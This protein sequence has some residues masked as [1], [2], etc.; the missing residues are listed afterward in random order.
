MKKLLVILMALSVSLGGFAE[1]SLND[2]TQKAQ[3]FFAKAG[4]GKK[5]AAEKPKLA[6]TADNQA[7]YVFNNGPQ[8]V[9][10]GD[11]I[12]G[13]SENGAFEYDK[14]PE[15]FKFYLKELQQGVSAK[16][17]KLVGVQ[18]IEPLTGAE[19]DQDSPYWGKIP[20]DSYLTGCVA[21]AL[22]QIMY[23][24]KHPVQGTGSKEYTYN[25]QQFSADFGNTTYDWANM[26]PTY[27]YSDTQ[28][29]KDAVATLMYHVGVAVS[30]KYGTSASTAVSRDAVFALYDYFGYD[31]G[32]ANETRSKYS[33]DAWKELIYNELAAGRPVFYSGS[34]GDSGHAFV[35]E[36][37]RPSDDK[38][39]F[40]WGWSGSGNGWFALNTSVYGYSG[41]EALCG[42]QPAQSPANI[43]MRMMGTAGQLTTC[44]T[45]RT[46]VTSL[47]VGEKFRLASDYRVRAC[48]ATNVDVGVRIQKIG[49]SE[50]TDVLAY[51][52]LNFN[53]STSYGEMNNI[54]TDGVNFS[55]LCEVRP[56]W[57]LAGTTD[58]QLMETGPD[59]EAPRLTISDGSHIHD[60]HATSNGDG[61]HTFTC[62]GCDYNAT[63]DCTFVNGEC[64]ICHAQE[65]TES[66]T[67]FIQDAV[68]NLF[69]VMDTNTNSGGSSTALSLGTEG[70]EFVVDGYPG[71]TVTISTE[72]GRQLGISTIKA[73]NFTNNSSASWTLNEV[74]D[75]IYKIQSSQGY[76]KQDGTGVG[77]TL[78]TDGGISAARTYRLIKTSEMGLN[79]A[80]LDAAIEEAQKRAI[81]DM[82]VVNFQGLTASAWATAI[83]NAQNVRD[84]ATTQDAVNTAA[85]TLNSTMN[86]LTRVQPKTG[87]TFYLK[88]VDTGKYLHLGSSVTVSDE[89]TALTLT[90]GTHGFTITDG[91]GH[92][93]SYNNAWGSLKATGSAIDFAI[94]NI[95]T[96]TVAFDA[97]NIGGS[98]ESL[99][100][101]NAPNCDIYRSYDKSFTHWQIEKVS[102]PMGTAELDDTGAYTSDMAGLY[103]SV[104]YTRNYSHT[105]WQA[106]Q[107]PFEMDYDDWKDDFIVARINTVHVKGESAALEVVTLKTGKL[108]A[109][110][111]YMIKPKTPGVKT[112]TAENV[113]LGLAQNGVIDCSSMDYIFTITG[114]YAPVTDMM[115]KGYYAMSNGALKQALNDDSSLSPYRW[116]MEITSRDDE[117]YAPR[118]IAIEEI[119]EE[120]VTGIRYYSTDVRRMKTTTYDLSGRETKSDSRG[121]YIID[122]KK[123]LK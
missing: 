71:T 34:S 95:D 22:A 86:G 17:K 72:D 105:K 100:V 43:R 80:A 13:Y 4:K 97:S 11:E 28:T 10:V 19:W 57:R 16:S 103:A 113:T 58:W 89:P 99:G 67:Y 33:D 79:Y 90:P 114:N 15:N 30:M 3:A 77:A 29:Q 52:N 64:T 88:H 38:F 31:A 96:E 55:G 70:T 53:M 106:I 110:T 68:S 6:Y 117:Y 91:E 25:S 66:P 56:I 74:E 26:L 7:F 121:L 49:S 61:T 118:M 9:I 87:D 36:G 2:A 92:S 5:L 94:V 76:W 23:K 81:G 93:V 101:E 27:G 44:T 40:N 41:H 115:S 108:K 73:W 102:T 45:P 123:I 47:N 42:I 35:C 32:M 116:Y 62:T 83:A 111:P 60:L 78:Y 59:W 51:S 39:Y 8:F 20:G 18:T 12:L 46:D 69:V 122:G 50:S 98:N 107:L 48:I 75:G 21:T 82:P 14:M 37:Y 119:G 112:L 84:N 85:T 109:N 1:V 104:S 24:W 120:T 54:S 63:E 65:A